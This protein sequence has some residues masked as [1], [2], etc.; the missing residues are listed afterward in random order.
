MGGMLGTEHRHPGVKLTWDDFVQ[1]PDDGQRHELIDGAHIVTPSPVLRHQRVVLAISASIW[2]YL[3]AHPLGEVYGSPVDVIFSNH[4]VVEPDIT[5]VSHERAK[6]LEPSSWIKGA[7]SLVVEVASP[8]TRKR[9][10]TVK[11]RLYERFG[12]DEYWFVDADA[13]TVTV[14]RR[15]GAVYG[16]PVTVGPGTNEMITT[17][18]LPG[19]ELALSVALGADSPR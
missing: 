12:V 1:F 17:P 3:Q 2:V 7:P 4:D 5:Y 9:D 11:L 10:L 16:P 14:F 15:D 19:F 6:T 18:L 13:G 8:S